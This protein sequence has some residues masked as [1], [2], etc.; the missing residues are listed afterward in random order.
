MAG[1]LTYMHCKL[2]LNLS[3]IVTQHQ[4][5]HAALLNLQNEIR[6][7]PPGMHPT[8][9]YYQE[10]MKEWTLNNH[11]NQK[12]IIEMHINETL[13]IH[14]QLLSLQAILP[15]VD[16]DPSMRI[17]R[18]PNPE[19]GPLNMNLTFNQPA[20]IPITIN[21]GM[22]LN[23]GS[24]LGYHD[25]RAPR[26]LG[27][28]APALGAFGTFMGIF[29]KAQIDKLQVEM[30]DTR[31]KH[32]RLVEVVANQDYHIQQINITIDALVGILNILAKNDPAI[33]SS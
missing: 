33:T 24:G 26:F 5:Y 15:Q 14:E 7:Y 23:S 4:H 6:K 1:S 30:Q 29:N 21:H 22:S 27:F 17:S 3:S 32:N 28:L 10:G 2:T 25:T 20:S 12:K 9:W 16:T 31:T 8:G 13:N 11:E 19:P 18:N